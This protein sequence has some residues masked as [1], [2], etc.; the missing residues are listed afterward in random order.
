MALK[1]CTSFSSSSYGCCYLPISFRFLTDSMHLARI[2]SYWE[3]RVLISQRCLWYIESSSSRSKLLYFASSLSA[4]WFILRKWAVPENMPIIK[5]RIWSCLK[6]PLS[7]W[8]RRKQRIPKR[9]CSRKSAV[10]F[11]I[12]LI[13]KIPRNF[14]RSKFRDLIGRDLSQLPSLIVERAIPR[15]SKTIALN[16]L[17]TLRNPWTYRFSIYLI[18]L[19]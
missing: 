6:F 17:H 8:W 11:G 14:D 3:K 5:S 7:S 9:T 16:L 1:I 18:Y 15:G 10:S 19:Q 13:L 4:C 2:L 12:S